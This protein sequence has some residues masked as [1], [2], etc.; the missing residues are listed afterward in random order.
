M[1]YT[2]MNRFLCTW[3]F[4]KT[5]SLK[6]LMVY[7]RVKIDSQSIPLETFKNASTPYKK[8]EVCSLLEEYIP[9]TSWGSDQHTGLVPHLDQQF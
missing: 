6:Q 1:L 8:N 4:T 5:L 2:Y 7:F 3:S 9:V